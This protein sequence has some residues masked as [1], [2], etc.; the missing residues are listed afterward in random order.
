[1][2]LKSEKIV[3]SELDRLKDSIL[4][5]SL[6]FTA[7]I[8]ITFML[9]SKNLIAQGFLIGSI[10]GMIY[11]RLQALY[12]KS[13]IEK[14]LKSHLNK[15][16][17]YSRFFIVIAVLLYSIKRPDL[18]NMFATFIGI[19]SV[20]VISIFVFGFNFFIENKKKLITN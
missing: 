19:F 12:A 1:M 18:F 8:V 13:I 16:I 10:A 6:L 17:S 20:H 9:L 5:I 14:D 11:L 4:L 2:L 7:I 15:I 3:K